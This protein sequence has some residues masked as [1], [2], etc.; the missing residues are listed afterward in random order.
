MTKTARFAIPATLLALAA[1]GGSGTEP[2]AE[3]APPA[4]AEVKPPEPQQQPL[5]GGP[6]PSLLVGQAWF[7]KDG[8]GKSKPGPARLEIWRETG[9]GWKTTRLEDP[10][11]NV[12]HKAIPYGGGIVTIAGEKAMVKKW[13]FAD[14]QWKQELLYQGAWGGQ[15]NRIRDLEI[16]DV[17]R[18]GKDEF[19]IATHDAGVVA[20]ISPDEGPSGVIEMDQKKD[21]FVHEIE[22]GDIDGD[23]K[24]EFAATPSGR[25]EMNRSQSGGVVLY[26]WDGKAYQ[27]TDIEPWGETHAKEIL[28]L[29]LDGDKGA[30]VLAVMEATTD[31][32]KKIVKPVEVRA[33]D[34][35]KAKGTFTSKVLAAIPDRQTR[36][37]VPGDFD[38]DG[39]QE[40]IAAAMTTGLWLLKKDPADKA[41]PWKA[42]C[43]DRE[44]SGF[45][46]TTYAADLDGNG[47]PEV[48]VA[49]DDQRELKRYVWN[50]ESGTFDKT[51]LGKLADD[52]ITWNIEYAKF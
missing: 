35:D 11:S 9:E 24:L 34:Y 23:G 50:K 33:Y 3:V 8:Q 31:G 18:D 19:V 36:F 39:E 10:D 51:V 28:I 41:G 17:D 45:E 5:E 47:V 2:P 16:G 49:A 4:A 46:H 27:K 22:I 42:T 48:Y 15:F 37:L 43:F 14:G 30:E 52:T 38:G 12:F 1:C 25:N 6:Y 29:E 21:T 26:R 40:L 44:S 7:W 13:T 32:S 20:V